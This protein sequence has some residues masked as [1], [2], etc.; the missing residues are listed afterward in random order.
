MN[1]DDLLLDEDALDWLDP[2]DEVLRM[3]SALA[4]WPGDLD[5]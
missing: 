1:P 4:E 5:D 3:D 2:A